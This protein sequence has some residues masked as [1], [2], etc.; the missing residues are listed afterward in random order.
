MHLALKSP[1]SGEAASPPQLPFGHA[2]EARATPELELRTCNSP[3]FRAGS[4][5]SA[6]GWCLRGGSIPLPGF[7][8]RFESRLARRCRCFFSSHFPLSCSRPGCSYGASRRH[9]WTTAPSSPIF[10]PRHTTMNHETRHDDRPAVAV[11]AVAQSAVCRRPAPGMQVAPW[12]AVGVSS[13]V[14]SDEGGVGGPFGVFN[15]KYFFSRASP[16]A[17]SGRL[18]SPPVAS[19]RLRPPLRP[20]GAIG[21]ASCGWRVRGR[22]GVGLG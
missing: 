14:L 18:R 10:E 22:S 4:V 1:G 7:L 12:T 2:G 13:L 3:G 20:L 9:S 21:R 17:A 5:E 19:G 15:K 16:P 6:R 11:T 8:L